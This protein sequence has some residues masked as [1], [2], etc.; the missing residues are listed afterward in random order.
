MSNLMASDKMLFKITIIKNTA[1][2]THNQ[3]IKMRKKVVENSVQKCQ[4]LHFK[5]G[6]APALQKI[7]VYLPYQKRF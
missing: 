7:S 2:Y 6:L 5:L 1:E 4:C 3:Q